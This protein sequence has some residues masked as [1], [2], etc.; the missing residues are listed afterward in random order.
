M[1]KAYTKTGYA[2]APTISLSLVAGGT[3]APNTTYYYRAMTAQANTANMDYCSAPSDVQSITTDTTNLSIKIDITHST[4]NAEYTWIWVNASADPGTGNW[5]RA[6]LYPN[7][8]ALGATSSTSITAVSTSKITTFTDTGVRAANNRLGT[9]NYGLYMLREAAQ[10]LVQVSGGTLAD[11]VT[12]ENIYQYAVA[13]SWDLNAT[14]NR[15]SYGPLGADVSDDYGMSAVST[16]HG[17]TTY[18]LNMKNLRFADYVSMQNLSVIN[19]ARSVGPQSIAGYVLNMGLYNSTADLSYNGVDWTNVCH[20]AQFGTLYLYN[21]KM[22]DT[23]IR[24][25]QIKSSIAISYS[26]TLNLYVTTGDYWEIIDSD[27]SQSF[28]R[29]MSV[30]S[31]NADCRI[32]RVRNFNNRWETN[33]LAGFEGTFSDWTLNTFSNSGPWIRTTI[34]GAETTVRNMVVISNPGAGQPIYNSFDTAL[35]PA[36][37]KLLLINPFLTDWDRGYWF[38]SGGAAMRN[39][40]AYVKRAYSVNALVVD[41]TGVGI[42][43]VTVK[44]YDKD[45]NLIFSEDTVSGVLP[46]QIVTYK[47]YRPSTTATTVHFFP[48]GRITTYSPFRLEFSKTG[49]ETYTIY[50]P[51]DEALDLVVSMDDKNYKNRIIDSVLYDTTIN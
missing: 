31:S 15:V 33:T 43:G 27:V 2:S 11:P 50:H 7:I 20:S 35:N 18:L 22:Y 8:Y 30:T 10:D 48:V 41:K 47:E 28:D 36:V 34:A 1:A 17:R 25:R 32:K 39:D 37:T 24:G 13:N 26:N 23:R 29:G 45:S 4:G 3:L 40:I 14:I 49:L 21:V 16:S 44:C 9:S 5:C 12:L 38:T 19:F 51:I 46:E 6:D 42:D